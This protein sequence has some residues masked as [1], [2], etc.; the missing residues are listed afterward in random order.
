MRGMMRVP[1]LRRHAALMGAIFGFAFALSGLTLPA[2]LASTALVAVL[3]AEGVLFVE[4]GRL[5]SQPGAAEL[6]Q[7]G[8]AAAAALEHEQAGAAGGGD[9]DLPVVAEAGEGAF[10]VDALGQAV[11]EQVVDTGEQFGRLGSRL[12]VGVPAA[13]PGPPSPSRRRERGSFRVA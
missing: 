12:W 10:Q 13:L 9:G 3:Q 7:V 6:D 4:A 8:A 1:R 11:G 2:A 5:D